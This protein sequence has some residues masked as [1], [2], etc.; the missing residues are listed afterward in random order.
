MNRTNNLKFIQIN[1]NHCRA[2]N[3]S[4]ANH[5]KDKDIDI[6]HVQDTYCDKTNQ[7]SSFHKTWAIFPSKNHNAHIIICNKSLIYTH[8]FTGLNC[9]FVSITTAEGNLTVGS[10]YVAPKTNFEDAIE[11]WEHLITDKNHFIC[12]GDFNA[13]SEL[14]GYQGSNVRGDQLIEFIIVNSLTLANDRDSR[15]TFV[16]RTSQGDIWPRA[17]RI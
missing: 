13:N 2:A 15:P 3:A 14:W 8:L 16:K 4:L 9:I 5:I 6:A 7:P 17:G 11:E 10:T 1:L 12:G